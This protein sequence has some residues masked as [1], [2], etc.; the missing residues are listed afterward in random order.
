[1]DACCHAT[2]AGGGLGPEEPRGTAI[3]RAKFRRGGEWESATCLSLTQSS[4]VQVRPDQ[5]WPAVLRRLVCRLPSS[6]ATNSAAPA[7][8]PAALRPKHLSPVP[9]LHIWRAGPPILA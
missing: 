7:S 9:T 8:T 4:S 6:S 5:R 3:K 1:M 2:T